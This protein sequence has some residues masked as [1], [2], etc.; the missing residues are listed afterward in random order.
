MP[1]RNIIS[2]N[3]KAGGDALRCVAIIGNRK[4]ALI[5]QLLSLILSKTECLSDILCSLMQAGIKGT[6]VLDCDGSLH[7]LSNAQEDAPPIF[8]S[9]RQ[10]LNPKHEHAKLLLVV[11][12]DNQVAQA[13]EIIN[14]AVGGI[15]KPDTGIMFTIALS[16]VE[17]LAQ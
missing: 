11:L 17:G 5:M 12:S 6:T 16:G 4:K 8:G 2:G 15:E 10:Y 3:R 9:L 7:L 14:K 13:K 1:D